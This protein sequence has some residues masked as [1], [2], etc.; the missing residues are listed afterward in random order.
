MVFVGIGVPFAFRR[1]GE[2]IIDAV[3]PTETAS[4]P[5]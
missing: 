2:L 3:R 4:R 1:D 5:A